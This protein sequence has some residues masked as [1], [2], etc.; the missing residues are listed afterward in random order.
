MPADNIYAIATAAAKKAGYSNFDKG[1][2]GEEKREEIVLALK[3]RGMKK[4]TANA[5]QEIWKATYG[6]NND[7]ARKTGQRTSVERKPRLNPNKLGVSDILKTKKDNPRNKP[8]IVAQGRENDLYPTGSQFAADAG[9]KSSGKKKFSNE[10]EDNE[11]QLAVGRRDGETDKLSSPAGSILQA[12]QVGAVSQAILKQGLLDMLLQKK[13]DDWPHKRFTREEAE[14]IANSR[15]LRSAA[16]VTQTY[17]DEENELEGDAQARLRSKK[18]TRRRKARK[19]HKNT[20]TVEDTIPSPEEKAQSQMEFDDNLSENKGDGHDVDFDE[21]KLYRSRGGSKPGSRAQK[22][23][24]PGDWKPDSAKMMKAKRRGFSGKDPL[25]GEIDETDDL[26]ANADM[27]VMSYMAKTH[28]GSEPV[29]YDGDREAR[30][31]ATKD[32]F[33]HL[34]LKTPCVCEQRGVVIAIGMKKSG[35]GSPL[36]SAE[37]PVAVM[38]AENSGMFSV[39]GKNLDIDPMANKAPQESVNQTDAATRK[40]SVNT[41]SR[42]RNTYVQLEAEPTICS[43]NAVFNSI[44]EKTYYDDQVLERYKD[45]EKGKT[46]AKSKD[47]HITNDIADTAGQETNKTRGI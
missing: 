39:D 20:T 31:K 8:N 1:S 45:A 38:S 27:G 28:F 32:H 37:K 43:S 44:L 15:G 14:R 30:I 13:D 11:H 29:S 25:D 36:A 10:K 34:L 40:A 41:D 19:A 46:K 26:H 21:E 17:I 2:D 9:D 42:G 22:L 23:I 6:A 18:N 3:R 16:D 47:R 24:P 12:E 35:N 4:A 5:V 33:K 7:Q